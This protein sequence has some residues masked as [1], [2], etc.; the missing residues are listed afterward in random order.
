MNVAAVSTR[1]STPSAVKAKKV[2]KSPWKL[3]LGMLVL[4]GLAVG[5]YFQPSTHP[6]MVKAIASAKKL[7]LPD[8]APEP[9]ASQPLNFSALN[10]P[11]NGLVPIDQDQEQA[12]GLKVVEVKKQLDPMKLELSGTTAYDPDSLHQ[13][14]LRF[15]SLVTRVFKTLGE[16]VERGDVLV[17]LHSTELATAKTEFQEKYV[18]WLY[19]ARLLEARRQLW[20]KQAIAH[21]VYTETK[22]KEAMSR[23]DYTLARQK[24]GVLGLTP[25]EIEPLLSG[26]TEESLPNLRNVD[27]TEKATFTLRSPASG[28]IIKRDVV[29]GTFYEPS[30]V[31]MVIAPLDHL[32]VYA[33]VYE[34]DIELIEKGQDIEVLFPF[35]DR[36]IMTKVENISNQVDPETHAMRV[37]TTIK[38]PGDLLKSDML[39]R[40]VLHIPSVPDD[41]VIP[42]NAMVST[43]GR[44]YVFVKK[45]ADSTAS[46]AGKD[47]K[48]ENGKQI[49]Y[50]ERKEIRVRQEKSDKVIVSEGLKA[51]EEVAANG[52]L[53]LAQMYEDLTT[54]ETGAPLR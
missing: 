28:Y 46:S 2:R 13:V 31:L 12:I 32:R 33:N 18:Q 51:G 19:D 36:K 11:W 47:R 15:D 50:F 16:P 9:T 41:T 17:E 20:E 39:V 53:I 37:R 3:W 38:N 35:Q 30:S 29:Q 23:L 48:D 25:E 22:N 45:P 40:A 5:A 21:I 49:D 26:L 24:L 4:V 1:V 44:Y 43:N 6:Y 8:H 54:V 27:L 10:K 7:A 14:R 52:S 34:S 42:R